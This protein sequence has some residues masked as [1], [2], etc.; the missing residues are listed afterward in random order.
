MRAIAGLHHVT[1]I[2]ADAQKN[3]DFYCGV[4]GLRLVKRTVNFDDPSSCHLYYGD[5]AGSPGTIMTFFVWPGG[6]RGRAGPPQVTATAFAV[7]EKALSFW[8]ARLDELGVEQEPA[9]M[10]MGEQLIH[11]WDPDGLAIELVGTKSVPH[12]PASAAGLVPPESAILGLHS[13]TISE[14]GYETTA[15][16]LTRTLG[17]ETAGNEGA[18]FRYRASQAE[19]APLVDLVCAPNAPRGALGTGIVHHVAFR[20]PGASEQLEWRKQLVDSGYNVSPVMDRS[21]FRSIYFRE[22]G[23][24]LLEIATDSPGFA[25]DESPEALGTELK[26]PSYYEHHRKQLEQ[27]LPKLTVPKRPGM[28]G[29]RSK[30]A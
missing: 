21:Y 2:S 8:A 26:L 3:I 22:P 4:L 25:V 13:V 16:L 11:A 18:R 10:R 23:G 17:F 15:K 1:A 12:R 7:P 9:V 19:C 30:A 24:V 6:V 27:L 14:E 5:E 28:N 29:G 20:T